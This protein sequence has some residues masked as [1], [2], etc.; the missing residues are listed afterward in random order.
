VKI[1]LHSA[2]I[3]TSVILASAVNFYLEIRPAKQCPL[4]NSPVAAPTV[5]AISTPELD[6][7]AESR[8]VV[9]DSEVIVNGKRVA[10]SDKHKRPLCEQ[11]KKADL[12]ES[13]IRLLVAQFPGLDRNGDG[14]A[15]LD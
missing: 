1:W 3:I 9:T 5:G 4:V 15:C 7:S 10:I 2:L 8:L 12:T 14:V 13:E 11:V 6:N